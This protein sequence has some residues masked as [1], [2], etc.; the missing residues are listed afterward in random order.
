MGTPTSVTPPPVRTAYR[1]RPLHL[2]IDVILLLAVA[3]LLVFGLIMV[4]SASWDQ[5]QTF[6]D[7]PSCVLENQLKWAIIGLAV[8]IACVFFNFHRYP[9]YVLLGML[10]TIGLLIVVLIVQDVRNNSARSLTGGSGRPSELAKLMIIL[11]MAVWLN[12]KRDVI[13]NIYFG[14]IPM[15]FILGIVGGLILLQPDLS[16]AAT[17]FILGGLLFFLANSDWRQI[18]LVF[19][20]SV[21]IGLLIVQVF[22]GGYEKI[23]SYVTGLNDPSAAGFHVQRSIEAIASGGLFGVGIGK[24]VTKFTG[25]PFSW[26]DSIFS[27]IVE[28]TG[29]LGG[30]AI[31]F[32]YGVILWR[33][34]KIAGAAKDMLGKLLAGGVTFW[35]TL[36]AL[37]NMGFLVGLLPSA[38]NAL[39]F[40]SAGGTSMVTSL[41]GIGILFNVNRITQLESREE[42]RVTSAVVDLRRW[43]RRR[44]VSRPVRPVG[45]RE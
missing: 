38:G 29:L 44:S 43:D 1:P 15:T 30:F 12:A 14:L 36:E 6:C 3:A 41:V 10:L 42:G 2:Q 8:A 45:N 32:L 26:T 35:I 4:Y 34:L 18:V 20:V 17:I 9:R 19:V 37:F 7:S 21:L 25:L 22:P 16:A 24:G 28:E 5:N 40:I 31:I 27:V 39:P 13:N 23:A 33:G 11:Y